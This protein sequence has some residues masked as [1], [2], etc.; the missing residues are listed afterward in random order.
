MIILHNKETDKHEVWGALTNI[1]DAH[2]NFSYTYLVK[3]KFPF[4]YKG[5]IFKKVKYNSK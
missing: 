5:W 1:C 4:E 3:K 2:P